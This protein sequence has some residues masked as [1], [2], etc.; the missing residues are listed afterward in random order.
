MTEAW[1][2]FDEAAIRR[3]AGNPN[4]AMP[5]DLPPLDRLERLPD[6]KRVLFDAIRT[7]SG[8]T[9]RR[10]KKLNEAESRARLA[11]LLRDFSPLRQLDAFA[12]LEADIQTVAARVTRPVPSGG[13]TAG[14]GC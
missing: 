5:L 3:A 11:E 1:L 2:L 9:R 6:P 4:G 13:T 14:S 10:L 12:R 7:A 8:R